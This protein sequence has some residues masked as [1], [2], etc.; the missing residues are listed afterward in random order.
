MSL[1]V[2]AS[3]ALSANSI[4]AFAVDA[5]RPAPPVAAPARKDAAEAVQEGSVRNWIEYYQREYG[6]T[7]MPRPAS[8]AADERSPAHRSGDDTG[9]PPPASGR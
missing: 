6:H 9:T 5:E 8:P 2:A 3:I 4:G 1:R 7:S